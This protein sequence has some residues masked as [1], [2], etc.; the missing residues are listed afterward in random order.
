[1]STRSASRCQAL[2][3]KGERCKRDATHDH[4]KNYYCMKHFHA[5]IN[6]KP[7]KVLAK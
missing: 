7:V 5:A 2:T 4:G 1:M 6:R 3:K